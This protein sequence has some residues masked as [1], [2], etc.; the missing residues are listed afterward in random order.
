[1]WIVGGAG[2]VGL[3]VVE[4][5]RQNAGRRGLADA[6]DAGEH[7]GLRDAAGLEGVRQGADHRLL[8]D[9]VLEGAGAVFA[10]K[11]PIGRSLAAGPAQAESPAGPARR[12]RACRLWFRPSAERLWDRTLR[13][14]KRR[15]GRLDEDPFGLVRAAS[16]RT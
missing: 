9:Q 8:A 15:G 2:A 16:F 1:M 3:L 14:Q 12:S 13:R 6:A 4:A 10:G 11:N 5:A 7:P